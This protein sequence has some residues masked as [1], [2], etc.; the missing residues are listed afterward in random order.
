VKGVPMEASK[1][2]RGKEGS[3]LWISGCDGY[4]Y[5]FICQAPKVPTS[6]GNSGLRDQIIKSRR[7]WKKLKTMEGNQRC[8]MEWLLV[9]KQCMNLQLQK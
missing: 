9:H 2:E 5:V 8:K 1:L 4:G 3:R 7:G 6:K